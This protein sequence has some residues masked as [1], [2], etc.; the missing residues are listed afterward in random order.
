MI[1]TDFKLTAQLKLTG[2]RAALE[3]VLRGRADSGMFRGFSGYIQADA[4]AVY[5]ALYRGEARTGAEEVPPKEVGCW[6]HARRRFWEAAVVVKD[7]A[8]REALLRLHTLFELE[9]EWQGLA[10]AQ[11]HARRQLTSR[12]LIDDFF[13]WANEH[14][15]RV[16]DARGLVATAFGYAVRQ[17]T[18][19]RGFLDDGRLPIVNDRHDP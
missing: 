10:P 6:A 16:K 9:D 12:R 8:A 3:L 5:D 11:R 18:G 2:E 15:A 13:L 7:A 4:S 1:A 14:Y 17:E 19:L